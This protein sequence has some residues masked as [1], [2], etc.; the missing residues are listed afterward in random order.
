[1]FH[2]TG[3]SPMFSMADVG[4]RV[5]LRERFS[6]HDFWPDVRAHGC[7]KTTMGAVFG[8]LMAQPERADDLDHPLRDVFFGKVG[9]EGW[10]F[11][12]RFGVR[13]VSCYGSTEVGFPIVNR[14]IGD[15]LHRDGEQAVPGYDIAGWLRRGYS[16]RIV[17]D[18]GDDVAG[19]PVGELWIR[20]DEPLMIMRE[21][22]DQ[23]ERTAAATAGG[24]YRTGDAV[25]QLD[26]G[27][28]VIVDRMRDTIRRFGENISS[29]ALESVVAGDP[30][31][32]DCAAVGVPS[33]ITGQEILLFVVPPPGVT[34]DPAALW[35][36]LSEVLPRHMRPAYVAVVDELPLTPTGK[37]R[38]VGL[39]DGFDLETAWRPAR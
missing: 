22:L 39:A 36:R 11:A 25:R 9:R 7:T 1:M 33:P 24:W 31:V 16:A 18:T 19:G 5:V 26:D 23:P 37:V 12:R 14:G 10:L 32:L 20:P 29:S 17:D 38:K 30:G 35:A 34:T 6:L 8:L 15:E 28:F 21:Y 3:R 13:A 2:V 4:G 27:G